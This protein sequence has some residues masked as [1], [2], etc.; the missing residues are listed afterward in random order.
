MFLLGNYSTPYPSK[1]EIEAI[2]K[3]GDGKVLAREPNPESIPDKERTVP[4]YCDPSSALANCSHF[5]IYQEGAVEPQLKYDMAH[6]KSLPL[7][8]LFSCIDNFEI[9]LPVRE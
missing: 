8:W 4:F 6:I 7:S 5:I 9:V 1:K 3:A 2:L